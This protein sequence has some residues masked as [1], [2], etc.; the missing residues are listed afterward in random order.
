MVNLGQPSLV[1]LC[2]ISHGPTSHGNKIFVNMK[3]NHGPTLHC[4]KDCVDMT[5]NNGQTW[6]TIVVCHIVQGLCLYKNQ[7]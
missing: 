3:I 1:M 4:D 6:L 2:E 5:I 7:P